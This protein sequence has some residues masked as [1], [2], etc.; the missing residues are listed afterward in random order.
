MGQDKMVSRGE[1]GYLKVL[2]EIDRLRQGIPQFCILALGSIKIIWQGV[3]YPC[4][5]IWPCFD[6]SHG[7]EAAGSN[8]QL[9]RNLR[10][11]FTKKRE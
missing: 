5:A 1:R 9:T 8:D 3:G 6:G 2:G 7:G 10:R 4:P 11:P